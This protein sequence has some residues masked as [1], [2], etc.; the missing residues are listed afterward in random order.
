MTTPR[1]IWSDQARKVLKQT[2]DYY[3]VK[4]ERGAKNGRNRLLQAPKTIHF[5]KQYQLDEV[6]PKYRR[7]IVRDYKLIYKETKKE[8]R[9]LDIISTEQSPD[10]LRKA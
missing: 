1:I 2:Y 10:I 4:P 7:I 6:N 5:S 8:V 3:K 9:I